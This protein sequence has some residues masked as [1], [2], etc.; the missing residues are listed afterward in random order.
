[1]FD[2]AIPTDPE[3]AELYEAKG[4]W[5]NRLKRND[6]AI[7][8]F[9]QAISMNPLQYQSHTALA[10]HY[11]KRFRYKEA[12]HEYKLAFQYGERSPESRVNMC[13]GYYVIGQLRDRSTV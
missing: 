3:E 6:E 9:K 13:I 4:N 5:L 12:L 10:A 2:R 8:A 7:A 11:V 1:M